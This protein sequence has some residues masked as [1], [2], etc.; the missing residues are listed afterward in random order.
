MTL[1]NEKLIIYIYILKKRISAERDEYT[2][3][4]NKN[5]NV[6]IPIPNVK[7]KMNNT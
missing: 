5:P 4:V 7:N 1:F 2:N 6:I 3:V